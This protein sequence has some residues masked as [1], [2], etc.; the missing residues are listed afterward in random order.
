MQHPDQKQ[1]HKKVQFVSP[2]NDNI[3]F[4][5]NKNIG[6]FNKAA[7]LHLLLNG[8]TKNYCIYPRIAFHALNHAQFPCIFFHKCHYCQVSPAPLKP[9]TGNANEL[10][11]Q[12]HCKNLLARLKITMNGVYCAR[13]EFQ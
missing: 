3:A 11:K 13:Q 1:L 7:Q 4:D 5:N 8:K 10:Q 6:E 12:T 2:L 9:L